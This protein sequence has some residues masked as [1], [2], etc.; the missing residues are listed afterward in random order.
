MHNARSQADTVI[1][2]P[3]KQPVHAV[4]SWSL[5]QADNYSAFT[6]HTSDWFQLLKAS[7]QLEISGYSLPR[8]CNW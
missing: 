2:F 7:S 5:R 3:A 4:Q 8:A 1:E 6:A